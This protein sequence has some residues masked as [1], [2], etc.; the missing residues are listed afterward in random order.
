MT[1]E[2]GCFSEDDV[3]VDVG[4]IVD[5]DLE[6]VVALGVNV[7]EKVMLSDCSGDVGDAVGVLADTVVVVCDDI[8]VIVVVGDCVGFV[9]EPGHVILMDPSAGERKILQEVIRLLHK[10]YVDDYINVK[11]E[12]IP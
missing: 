7:E 4:I 10:I 5:V 2:V 8:D 6:N 12:Y 1:Y 11:P 3:I 9:V